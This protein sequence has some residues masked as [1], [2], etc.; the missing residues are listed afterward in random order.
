MG[1]TRGSCAGF[2]P[3]WVRLAVMR[4]LWLRVRIM[5]MISVAISGLAQLPSIDLQPLS[6]TVPVG[7]NVRLAVSVASLSPVS[8]QWTGNGAVLP[9]ETNSVLDLFCVS[10]LQSNSQYRVI[11]S[12]ASGAV[13]SAPSVLSVVVPDSGPIVYKW[14]VDPTASRDKF[15]GTAHLDE[16][17]TTFL[18]DVT[19]DALGRIWGTD[20]YTHD[21]SVAGAAVHTGFLADGE[22]G[23]LVLRILAGQAAYISSDRHGVVSRA[24]GAYG[25]SFELIGRVPT[26]RRHPIHQVRHLGGIAEF[27]VD[28]QGRGN[29]SYQWKHNGVNL[30]GE[31]RETLQMRVTSSQQAGS[32]A[33][34]VTDA[35]GTATS[36]HAVLGVLPEM[37]LSLQQPLLGSQVAS[38]P[39]GVV[40]RGIITGQTNSGKVWGTGFYAVDSDLGLAAVHAGLLKPNETG[41][42]EVVQVPAVPHFLSSR[43]GDV[44]S[45]AYGPYGAFALMG[46]VPMIQEA[47]LSQALLPGAG[48]VLRVSATHPAPYTIQW[49]RDGVPIPGATWA[50]LAVSEL[51]VGTTSIYDAVL[52]VPGGA[53]LS[54]AAQVLTLGA[55]TEP[56]M[57]DGPSKLPRDFGLIPQLFNVLLTAPATVG[58]IWGT[59]IYTYD[60]PLEAAALHAG[61]LAPGQTARILVYALGPQPGFRGSTRN[62]IASL[63]FGYY[64]GSYAFVFRT[65]PVSPSRLGLVEAGQVQVFGSVGGVV[66]IQST[67]DLASPNW[68]HRVL[69]N[70]AEPAIQWVDPDFGVRQR[71][72]RSRNY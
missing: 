13:T 20:V 32:Y 36:D 67:D 14:G 52:S 60:S 48:A 53:N 33:V 27:H 50:S 25:G 62:G 1:L 57:V 9:K 61:V 18:V 68:R 10:P 51:A 42:L 44:T 35:E 21:S 66:E 4:H 6:P 26:L 56:V 5:A 22:R 58:R 54:A 63:S 8:L 47:P 28:A 64:D 17:G 30:V 45:L 29:L 12:N 55:G 15:T 71:Y 39:I 24:Y 69:L 65:S 72:Y 59:G 70:L 23:T 16:V 38:L 34:S 31:T 11:A 49:R 46:R 40:T 19:G 41:V 7:M 43:S 2:L 3:D 37:V